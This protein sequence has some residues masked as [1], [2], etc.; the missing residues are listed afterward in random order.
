[1]R[2]EWEE[3]GRGVQCVECE[4]SLLLLPKKYKKKVCVWEGCGG[5]EDLLLLIL[6]V[7]GRGQ[8]NDQRV[9]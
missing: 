2:L 4:I 1:M 7:M 9:I 5:Q 3:R 6:E 8:I